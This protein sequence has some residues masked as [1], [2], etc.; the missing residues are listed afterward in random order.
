[1]SAALGEGWVWKL[2]GGLSAPVMIAA[3]WMMRRPMEKAGLRAALEK[4]LMDQNDRLDAHIDRQDARLRAER[5]RC[6]AELKDM[7]DQI[8]ALMSGP[9]ATYKLKGP[10]GER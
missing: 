2:I 7:R 1:M 6:D 3:G 10:F 5:E 9:V 8:N 4:S